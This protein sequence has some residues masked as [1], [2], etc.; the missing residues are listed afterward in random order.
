L[1]CA[2][3]LYWLRNTAHDVVPSNLDGFAAPAPVPVHLLR[4]TGAS[5]S[6]NLPR[7]FVAL[8]LLQSS[9]FVPRPGSWGRARHGNRSFYSL[10]PRENI[11]LCPLHRPWDSR[12]T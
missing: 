2:A 11:S 9:S 4:S 5:T 1:C 10:W 12:S 3:I 7:V 8:Y 6:A